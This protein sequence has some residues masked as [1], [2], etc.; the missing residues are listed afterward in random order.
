MPGLGNHGSA[1]EGA[2]EAASLP[3]AVDV[4]D[5]VVTRAIIGSAIKAPKA[6]GPGLLESVSQVCRAH[7]LNK[8]GIPFQR[9]VSLPVVYDDVYLDCGFRL[10][11]VVAEDLV[12]EI[13]CVDAVAN[14][15]FPLNAPLNM[16]APVGLAP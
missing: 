16:S 6:L 1:A 14:I 8:R 5:D 12:L 7:E 15:H 2:E 9:E 13:K 11:F 10:D 4:P 3:A